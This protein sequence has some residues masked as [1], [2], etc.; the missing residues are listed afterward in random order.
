MTALKT[1]LYFSIFK[2][3]LSEEEIYKF[4]DTSSKETIV[5][6]LDFLL[7]KGI[8]FKFD[9]FFSC[10]NN[11]EL[12]SRRLKGNTMA[13][14]IMPKAF[15]VSKLIAKFPYVESVCLS[16]SLSKGYYDS[17]GD[18]DFFII[19]KPGR[20][21]ISRTL[22]ILYKKIFLLNS[23]KYFCVNYFIS[24]DHL[25]IPEQN[26]FTATE[27]V[28]L[29]PVYGKKAFTS[30]M[31]ENTWTYNYFPNFSSFDT[32]L[33]NETKKSWLSVF[34]EKM[35]NTPIGN[36][37]DSF[38]RKMTLKKWHSKFGDLESEDFKIA[39]K[40][41]KQVSKHHPQNFQKKVIDR[42]NKDYNKLKQQYN[43]ELLQD[44]A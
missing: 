17:D 12:I 7:K 18:I 19:T 27:M 9:N 33:I 26:R 34:V 5:Q 41:T 16:G 3:P 14:K 31:Q 25:H 13:K 8:I 24:S 2:Y 6:E 39:M 29:I 30:L 32:S 4:S 22:L 43:L 23:R 38:L 20:L 42:L 44:Y 36:A 21:W 40:S 15:K 10:L 35:L 37:V 28:T 11:P 1:L